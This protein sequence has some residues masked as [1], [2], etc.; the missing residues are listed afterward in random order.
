MLFLRTTGGCAWGKRQLLVISP[1]WQTVRLYPLGGSISRRIVL[2]DKRAERAKSKTTWTRRQ[3]ALFGLDETDPVLFE[4][5]D[6][7]HV[8]ELD[9]G[10]RLLVAPHSWNEKSAVGLEN[11][12]VL[13]RWD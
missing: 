7:A 8:T 11:E 1:L 5:L 13:L 6:C 10:G 3:I 2:G 9:I 12:E 4:R